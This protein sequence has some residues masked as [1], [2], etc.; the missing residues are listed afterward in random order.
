MKFDRDQK[1]QLIGYYEHFFLN[2]AWGLGGIPFG[3]GDWYLLVGVGP[4]AVEY[5]LAYAAIFVDEQDAQLPVFIYVEVTEDKVMKFVVGQSLDEL[6]PE[7]PERAL[8]A[9]NAVRGR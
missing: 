3:V 7:L 1:H 9:V 4:S 6:M 5:P 2:N 8:E